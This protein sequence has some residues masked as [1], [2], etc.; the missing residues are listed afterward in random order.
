M[1]M[2]RKKFECFWRWPLIQMIKDQT[3]EIFNSIISPNVTGFYF[4]SQHTHNEKQ[5]ACGRYVSV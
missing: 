3:F 5:V 1:Q 2:L 4:N